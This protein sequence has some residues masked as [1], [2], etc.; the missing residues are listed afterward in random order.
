[1]KKLLSLVISICLLVAIMAA[2]VVVS[3]EDVNW[4]L[5]TN[6][7]TA[8]VGNGTSAGFFG[9]NAIDGS[10]DTRYQAWT[11]EA[12]TEKYVQVELAK[13]ISVNKI[14][15]YSGFSTNQ[16]L[17]T[18][19]YSTDGVTWKSLGI[20]KD[21]T[22]NYL[23]STPTGVSAKYIKVA[24][25]QNSNLQISELQ[26]FG[27]PVS[28]AYLTSLSTASGTFTSAFDKDTT[29]YTVQVDDLA[30]LP[31]LTYVAAEG[32]T[33]SI[34]EAASADNGYV[35]KI[36]VT[37]GAYTKEYT[38]KFI[39]YNW[40]L[41]ANGTTI[42]AGMGNLVDG[43]TIT[44]YYLQNST[45]AILTFSDYLNI[46]SIRFYSVGGSTN[47]TYYKLSYS[48]DG[49]TWTEL[50][51]HTDCQMAVVTG[52]NAK[53][54]PYIPVVAKYVKFEKIGGTNAGF[55]IQ[56]IEVSG[57]K[58]N[59]SYTVNSIELGNKIKANVTFINKTAVAEANKCYIMA[60]YHNGELY[61]VVKK[62]KSTDSIEAGGAVSID[63][64]SKGLPSNGTV[65]ARLFV[66]SDMTTIKPVTPA[67]PL[68]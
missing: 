29:A 48:L 15:F 13:T 25:S 24:C 54:T 5:S 9:A 1:M 68:K 28:F 61:D 55:K 17:Y 47:V 37:D 22:N 23:Y 35:T 42:S 20:L 44:E 58:I 14:V 31:E 56:E 62:D 8:S 2:P 53:Y 21:T 66:W 60:V 51:P 4:A 34:T 12:A 16:N 64:E 67:F 57:K 40:A 27:T 59:D 26:V 52:S 65:T 46:D 45:P 39:K 38:V 63:F 6:G 11:Q 49:D 41:A 50:R 43:D 36:A 18:L 10:M 30:N 33:A 3:A 19:S 32:A 7:A